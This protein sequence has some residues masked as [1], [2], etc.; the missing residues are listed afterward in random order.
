MSATLKYLEKVAEAALEKAR[1]VGISVEHF[2]S[3]PAVCIIVAGA[4]ISQGRPIH[5]VPWRRTLAEIGLWKR[6]IA[7]CENIIRDER[8]ITASEDEREWLTLGSIGWEFYGL[9]DEAVKREPPFREIL[10]KYDRIEEEIRAERASS[11]DCM[12]PYAILRKKTRERGTDILLYLSKGDC[13]RSIWGARKLK[14]L[15]G[16]PYGYIFA[17][18]PP[19]KYDTGDALGKLERI[20]RDIS[21]LGVSVIE[22]EWW[23]K[24]YSGILDAIDKPREHLDILVQGFPRQ[25]VYALE[26]AL[27]E[28]RPY[29]FSTYYVKA[30]DYPNKGAEVVNTTEWTT[31]HNVIR[32]TGN[33]RVAVFGETTD[34]R[35]KSGL[36]GDLIDDDTIIYLFLPSSSDDDY[37]YREELELDRKVQNE[38]KKAL[39]ETEQRVKP[40]YVD[41]TSPS[42]IYHKLLY[43]QPE[44][45]IAGGSRSVTDGISKYCFQCPSMGID[46]P[47]IFFSHIEAEV[48]A[49]GVIPRVF[50][51]E[52]PAYSSVVHGRR[53]A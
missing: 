44:I 16:R 30:P 27:M 35:L 43:T 26:M 22:R 49:R 53:V 50:P 15:R 40:M 14:N 29:T 19:P 2:G 47:R 52:G 10:Q 3:D 34:H 13:E 25:A 41:Y 1:A 31:G 11:T 4:V 48:Y 8:W 42:S 12:L 9:V 7:Q 5:L 17:C 18:C 28:F 24:D 45:I 37:H 38:S 32:G 33:K 39:A 21:R 46:I 36:L 51:L 6:T 23:G 20:S